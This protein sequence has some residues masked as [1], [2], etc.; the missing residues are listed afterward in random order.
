LPQVFSFEIDL[1][2][3]NHRVIEQNESQLPGTEKS[4]NGLNPNNTIIRKTII[5]NSAQRQ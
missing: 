1:T 2:K 3:K 4:L 5:D